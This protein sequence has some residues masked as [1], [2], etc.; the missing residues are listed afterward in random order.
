MINTYKARS[1]ALG[2][3]LWFSLF[4][5]KLNI[6][7]FSASI[8]TFSS[9]NHL[10][11]TYFAKHLLPGQF[12]H[13]GVIDVCY[14]TSKFSMDNAWTSKPTCANMT[15]EIPTSNKHRTSRWKE[16]NRTVRRQEEGKN[17]VYLFVFLH[18]LGGNK[19]FINH[20]LL[21]DE[22]FWL[23]HRILICSIIHETGSC[24]FDMTHFFRPVLTYINN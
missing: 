13:S 9:Q 12:V 16:R 2:Y 3:T 17:Y 1:Q 18:E 22:T 19:C 14:N 5:L 24:H 10:I 21:S 8:L 15:M 4:S 23:C 11:L 6:F 7:P 20:F